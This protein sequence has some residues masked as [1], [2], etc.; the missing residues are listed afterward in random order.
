[1]GEELQYTFFQKYTN[2]Q[3]AHEKMLS[4]ISN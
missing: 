1:M 2:G 4:I 3:K